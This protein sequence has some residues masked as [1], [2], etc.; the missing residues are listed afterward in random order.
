MEP[1]QIRQ[2]PAVMNAHLDLNVLKALYL[3]N[4]HVLQELT[5]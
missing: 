4:K 5:H 3:K 2:E 1:T